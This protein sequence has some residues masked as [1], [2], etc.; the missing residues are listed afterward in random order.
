MNFLKSTFILLTSLATYLL[1]TPLHAAA[2]QVW[3]GEGEF[4]ISIIEGNSESE[5]ISAK[6]ELN[7]HQNKWRHKINFETLKSKSDGITEDEYYIATGK[8]DY[9]FREETYAFGAVRY[10]EDRFSSFEHQ[11]SLS[12]GY[13]SRFISNDVQTLD[14]SV[15]LGVKRSEEQ[16]TGIKQNE[17]ILR[18][19]GNY[20]HKI[21][22]HSEFTEELLIETGEDNTL[23]ESVT[24]FKTSV[25][26]RIATKLSYSIKHNSNVPVGTK[27]T[28]KKT[29]VTV[30][31]SF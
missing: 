30:V 4:G 19:G 22:A 21:G 2:D 8:S 31:F 9:F 27:N 1:V 5:D 12:A 20:I 16:I 28:D 11:L 15:G 13:G 18:L 29:A 24:G 3:S 23:S 14:A 26:K 7:K 10:E 6:L 17:V 25:T